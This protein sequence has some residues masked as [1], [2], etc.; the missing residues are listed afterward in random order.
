MKH[1][2]LKI[3]IEIKLEIVDEVGHV[4]MISWIT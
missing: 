3:T 4:I 1:E 2:E